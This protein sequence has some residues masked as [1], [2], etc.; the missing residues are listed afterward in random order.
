MCE[1]IIVRI[2][3]KQLDVQGILTVKTENTIGCGGT[4]WCAL[5]LAYSMLKTVVTR[6][7]KLQCGIVVC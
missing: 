4:L 2:V 1:Y 5:P 6:F 3:G 7:A